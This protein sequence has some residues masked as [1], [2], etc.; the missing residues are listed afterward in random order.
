ML[1]EEKKQKKL[2]N[3]NV[4]TIHVIVISCDEQCGYPV[5]AYSNIFQ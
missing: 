1:G 5:S 4:I 2:I 3:A